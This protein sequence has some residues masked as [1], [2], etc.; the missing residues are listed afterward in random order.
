MFFANIFKILLIIFF[1]YSVV[2]VFKY[3]IYLNRS[4][5][6]KRKNRGRDK[7]GSAGSAENGKIIELD[8][9]QY[10]VE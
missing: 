9:D 10:K 4:A 5:E 2:N 6:Q 3:I 7:S 1:V 8:K